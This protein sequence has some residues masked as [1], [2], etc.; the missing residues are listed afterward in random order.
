MEK[1]RQALK[2]LSEAE[3]QLRMSNDRLTWLTAA[4]LQL[5]PDQQY[6]LPSSSADTSFTHSPLPL[7]DRDRPRKS[8]AEN[9]DIPNNVQSGN[10]GDVSHNGL[11]RGASVDRRRQ[12]ANEMVPKL[13]QNISNDRNRIASEELAGKF[14]REIEEIW[15]EV[16]EKIQINGIREF[17]LRE[18][19]LIS[20]GFGAGTFISH[21]HN[22]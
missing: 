7:R 16:V 11:V 1:L 4:L 5:A 12:A 10:Y 2:T 3:K 6:I 8:N 21:Y 14:R 9:T 17:L 19:K 13:P 22:I 18:G 15:L 20:V